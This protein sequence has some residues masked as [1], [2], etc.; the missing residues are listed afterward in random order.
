[1]RFPEL[2]PMRKDLETY[3]TST[4]ARMGESAFCLTI[5][6]DEYARGI[7][8]LLQ[9]ALAMVLDK[10]IWLLCPEVPDNVRKVARRIEFFNPKDKASLRGATERLMRAAMEKSLAA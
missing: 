3:V 2:D 7:D 1:M 10:P 6:T 4:A 5:F 8:S 9:L